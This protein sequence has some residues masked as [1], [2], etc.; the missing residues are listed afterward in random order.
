MGSVMSVRKLL[1]IYYLTY[2]PK[3]LNITVYHHAFLIWCIFLT[4]VCKCI[5]KFEFIGNNEKHFQEIN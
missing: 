1:F 4:N 3:T 5:L 2:F